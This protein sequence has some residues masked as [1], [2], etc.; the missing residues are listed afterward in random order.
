MEGPRVYYAKWNV[1][2]RKTNTVWF[3]LYVESK[4]QN[5]QKTRNRIIDTQNKLVV[6]GEEGVGGIGKIDEED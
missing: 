5:K 4:K 1:R 3:H 2:Q 6:A